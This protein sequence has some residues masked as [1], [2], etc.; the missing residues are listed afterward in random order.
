MIVRVLAL[1]LATITGWA[2]GSTDGKHMSH[3]VCQMPSTG[4][5]IGRYLSHFSHWLRRQI[6]RE[7]TFEADRFEVIFESP[8]LSGTTSL[9]TARKLY[10]LAGLVELACFDSPDIF[11][12]EIEVTEAHQQNIRVHFVGVASASKTVRGK[13]ER[14]AWI[15]KRVVDECKRR[16]FGTVSDDEGDA[17]ALRSLRLAQL[18][19]DYSL[20]E[21]E[22]FGRTP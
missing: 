7:L 1:D 22:L 19:P 10:S 6:L 20:R 11:D 17:I 9:A 4:E 5:D 21:T 8:I 14:R 15:K 2:S 12:R 13:K 16:G 3:G 18:S